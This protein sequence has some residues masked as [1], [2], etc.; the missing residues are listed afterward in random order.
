MIHVRTDRQQKE[1]A[2]LAVRKLGACRHGM[3]A[4]RRSMREQGHL[5]LLGY[6]RFLRDGFVD[7]SDADCRYRWLLEKLFPWTWKAEIKSGLCAAFP[8][9]TFSEREF[10]TVRANLVSA[11]AVRD[12]M[13]ARGKR[14]LAAKQG[15]RTRKAKRAAR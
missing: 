7:G 3:A 10:R 15:A 14:I 9:G 12:E 1:A 6:L 13:L 5:D 8:Q 4:V 2:L 11:F